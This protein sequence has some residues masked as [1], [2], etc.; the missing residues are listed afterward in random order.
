MVYPLNRKVT[1]MFYC[2][3]VVS[4]PVYLSRNTMQ[5]GTVRH[6]ACGQILQKI[7]FHVYVDCYPL[8]PILCVLGH[9]LSLYG[10]SE[11]YFKKCTVLTWGMNF[12]RCAGSREYGMFF[13]RHAL[14]IVIWC[15]SIKHFQKQNRPVSGA[16][17]WEIRLVVKCERNK[18]LI[19]SLLRNVWA[20][21]GP[22]LASVLNR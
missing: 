13:V 10:N 1:G 4:T 11:Y 19:C 21:F 7:R 20:I 2:K 18:A 17:I 14:P 6:Y 12:R 15:V 9:T 3:S 5:V 8:M 16:R 22:H